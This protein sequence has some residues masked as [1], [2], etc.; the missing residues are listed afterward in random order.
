MMKRQDK[1]ANF[2]NVRR[3]VHLA[4]MSRPSVSPS[5]P[6]GK[7]RNLEPEPTAAHLGN[8][9]SGMSNA[10]LAV[11]SLRPERLIQLSRTEED[12][13]QPVLDSL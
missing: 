2:G 8:I 6:E 12:I 10:D 4:A 7:R 13:F 3:E 9:A 5:P 1:D 11:S